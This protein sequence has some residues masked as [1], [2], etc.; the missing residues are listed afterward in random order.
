MQAV[1]FFRLVI[2]NQTLPAGNSSLRSYNL[3]FEIY[4]FFLICQ[5]PTRWRFGCLFTLGTPSKRDRCTNK[6]VFNLLKTSSKQSKYYHWE[7]MFRHFYSSA[8]FLV[9]V[10][11]PAAWTPINEEIY[12]LTKLCRS[13]LFIGFQ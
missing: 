3:F 13:K 12:N 10:E 5:L 4:Y 8:I 1:H 7:R 9:S 6:P 2:I 11:C